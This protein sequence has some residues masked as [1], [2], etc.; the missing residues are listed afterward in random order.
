MKFYLIQAKWRL[1]LPT[2]NQIASHQYVTEAIKKQF[3]VI[4]DQYIGAY[5][6]ATMTAD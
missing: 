2:A 4:L 1:I 6:T 3:D 5:N